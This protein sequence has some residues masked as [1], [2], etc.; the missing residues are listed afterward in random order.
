MTF[1]I[2]M[3]PLRSIN[4]KASVLHVMILRGLLY[5]ISPAASQGKYIVIRNHCYGRCHLRRLV[6]RNAWNRTKDLVVDSVCLR[7]HRRAMKRHTTSSSERMS[8]S[9]LLMLH[10]NRTTEHICLIHKS[11]QNRR[12][13][14]RRLDSAIG[15]GRGPLEDFVY[16][17]SIP[18]RWARRLRTVHCPYSHACRCTL[19]MMH[20]LCIAIVCPFPLLPCKALVSHFDQIVRQLLHSVGRVPR[21]YA[22]RVVCEE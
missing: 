5:Y 13:S 14:S 7:N 19:S 3:T 9:V 11:S 12:T 6:L 2:V 17:P 20:S 15:F 18:H 16:D 10:C 1:N 21:L 4:A 22:L 8:S